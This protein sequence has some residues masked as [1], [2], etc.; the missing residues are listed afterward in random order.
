MTD[1]VILSRMRKV[2]VCLEEENVWL[3]LQ[4]LTR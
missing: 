4:Q 1:I 3:S 2:E